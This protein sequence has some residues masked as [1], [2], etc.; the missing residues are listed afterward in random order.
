MDP[1]W[2][3][4]GLLMKAPRHQKPPR[5]IL[6]N[7]FAVDCGTATE[8]G[9]C[10]DDPWVMLAS[11]KAVSGVGTSL[12]AVEKQERAVAVVLNLANPHWAF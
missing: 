2:L 10:T 8:L 5:S 3:G 11:V 12:S 1:L 9:G 4:L 6:H 7:H